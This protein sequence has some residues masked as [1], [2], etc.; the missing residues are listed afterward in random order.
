MTKNMRKVELTIDL[1]NGKT[2]VAY[3]VQCPP[4]DDVKPPTFVI[5]VT[6]CPHYSRRQDVITENLQTK[7][8]QAHFAISFPLPENS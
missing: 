8:P 5:M 1:C 6:D 7:T 2:D 4:L 3:R